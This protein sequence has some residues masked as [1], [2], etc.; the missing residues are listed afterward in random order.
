MLRYKRLVAFVVVSGMLTVWIAAKISGAG[1]TGH[2]YQLRATFDDATNLGAGDPVKLAGVR[3]GAV[4]SV[5][6]RTGKAVVTFTVDRDVSLPVDTEVDVQAVDLIGRRQLRLDP[7]TDSKMLGNGDEVTRTMSAVHLGKL[8]NE[9]G[10]LLEAVRPQQVNQLVSALN[11]ALSGNRETI[12]GLT[13]DLSKVLDTAANRSGTIASL[14]DDYSVLVDELA[15][16]DSSI[17]RLLDNLVRLT[18]TFQASG[19]VLTR[20]LDTLPTTTDALQK[21]L[22]D[23]AANVDVL[24]HDLSVISQSVRPKLTDI[25]TIVAGLPLVL[26]KVWSVVDDGRYI[27]IDFACVS[28]TPPPCPHPVAGQ[29]D[30]DPNGGLAQTLLTVLGL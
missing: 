4:H 25:D 20:A 30:P 14:T 1:S 18:E 26:Q 11:T 8:I 27:K 22:D 3:V 6:L 10:P 2:H 7:G 29:T 16:R 21:L 13:S 28:A 17:Q 23:N 24:V 19:D 15:R 12:A 9:L 5:R